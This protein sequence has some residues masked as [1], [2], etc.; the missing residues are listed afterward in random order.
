MTITYVG[1]GAWGTGQGAPLSQPQ[2]DGNVFDHETRIAALEAIPPGVGIDDITSSGNVVTFHLSNDTTIDIAF[3][4]PEF[5]P[6]GEWLNDTAYAYPDLVTVSN[7]GVFLV[8]EP[9]TTPAAPAEFDPNAIEENTDGDVPLYQL[10][11]PQ[12]DATALLRYRGAWASAQQYLAYDVITEPSY[13]TFVVK[14]DH[15]SDSTFDPNAFGDTDE[16]LLYEQIAPPPFAA[17]DTVIGATREVSLDDV[18]RYLRFTNASGCA[19]TFPGDVEFVVN[20]EI[21]FEQAGAGSILFDADNTDIEIIPQR[22][23]YDTATPYQ[24][25]VVTAKYIAADTW[26]LI[27]PHGDELGTA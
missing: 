8:K 5:N 23:G 4:L 19:V 3:E 20:T 11:L 13:G 12:Q 7:L 6:R 24:G 22:A 1:N 26:K 14:F 16:D 9:H 10:M 21:H 27:G 18:G 25:A 15:I 2:H 17:V